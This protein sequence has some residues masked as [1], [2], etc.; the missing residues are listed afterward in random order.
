MSYEQ[1]KGFYPKDMG[2]KKGWCLQN[3]AKGFHAYPSANPSASA[4]VDMQI[5]KNKGTFHNGSSDIPMNCAVPVYVDTPSVYEHVVVCDKGTWYE[6]GHKSNKPSN[7]FGWGEWCNGFQIVKKTSSTKSFLPAKG[8]WCVGDCDERIGILA[9]FMYK[10]FPAYSNKKALGNYM[11][12]F[13]QSSIREFQK[14]TGL[15]PDGCVGKIT[16]AE[17]Q[18]YGFKY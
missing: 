10:T 13:L 8:Y 9:N 3:V 12:K 18:K 6:D 7:I 14:R 17:L 1:V 16:Y 4:K 2:S 15:Y 11:G 5:N